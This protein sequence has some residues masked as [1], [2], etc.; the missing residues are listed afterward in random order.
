MN[1]QETQAQKAAIKHLGDIL[2]QRE[3]G[4]NYKAWNSGTVNRKIVQSGYSRDMSNMTIDQLM[5][6]GR[7]GN[8]NTAGRVF[9]AGKYQITT[10]DP[11]HI[12]GTLGDAQRALKLD[13]NT[14]FSDAEQEE[15]FEKYLI[16]PQ[17]AP[18]AYGYIHSG[19]G[20]G[21][22]AVYD[23]AKIWRSIEVPIGKERFT[24]S[25]PRRSL[26]AAT[27]EGQSYDDVNKAPV[28]SGKR[29]REAVEQARAA[30]AGATPTTDTKTRV[31]PQ[32]T[33]KRATPPRDADGYRG[34]Q[35]TGSVG[36]G[37]E[38]HVDDVIAV[39]TRLHF[40]GIETKADGKMGPDTLRA[41]H[42]FQEPFHI[43]DGLIEK[44]RRSAKEL[45]SGQVTVTATIDGKP[46]EPTKT[47]PTKTEPSKKTESKK[48]ES[49]KTDTKKTE[50]QKPDSAG[51]Y[52]F[53]KYKSSHPAGGRAG[54]KE[55]EKY[56][57]AVTHQSSFAGVPVRPNVKL[58]PQIVRTAEVLAS[59]LP[60]GTQMTSGL[61]DDE[62]QARVI[63][64]LHS[65][66]QNDVYKTWQAAVAAGK[67][68]NWVGESNHR[69]GNAMDFSGAALSAIDAA[70][71]K[72]K[73]EHTEAKIKG[74]IVEQGNNCLHVNV[75]G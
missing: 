39:Q 27:K 70:V 32:T 13:G 2:S 47:E 25:T 23:L 33:S 64:G 34:Y 69:P 61:R 10:D 54:K 42:A 71:K 36:Q 4:G 41:I 66:V 59:H 17:K 57:G 65:P 63:M 6:S 12:G 22:D 68:V 29:V 75:E 74:T 11:K 37:G 67:K 8:A 51:V 19:S 56:A 62:D 3:S 44:S 52:W 20:T 60:K 18:H 45:F 28:G 48:T 55:T 43:H 5:A 30:F 38:N 14:K 16:G 24:A 50:A 49:K 72:C 1:D 15:I 40:F 53:G 58:T 31:P 46:A 73:A 7:S 21:D 26:G 35:L 9:A